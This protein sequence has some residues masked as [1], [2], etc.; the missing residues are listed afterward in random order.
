MEAEGLVLHAE[1]LALRKG[2]SALNTTERNANND[3]AYGNVWDDV[4][5]KLG[6]NPAAGGAAGDAINAKL[7]AFIQ[8]VS[9]SLDPNDPIARTLQQYGAGAAGTAAAN[10]GI[11]GG[12]SVA[13]S[14]QGANA[15]L[16]PYLQQRKQLELQGVGALSQRDLALR[17]AALQEL[18]M[19]NQASAANFAMQ[20][21]QLASVGSAVGGVLGTV[22]QMYGLPVSGSMGSQLVGG[23]AG[24]GA[25]GGYQ[26]GNSNYPGYGYAGVPG[27]SSYNSYT[28]AHGGLNGGF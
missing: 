14:E 6:I 1:V 18:Q 16:L 13:A 23:L 26:S 8:S 25:Q 9:G 11:K 27:N 17:Q 21:N 12:M 19:K 24:M 5:A 28:P 22:G 2:L 20:Q 4:Y 3:A 10:A 15:A 7:A